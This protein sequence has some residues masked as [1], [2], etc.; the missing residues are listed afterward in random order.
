MKLSY[1]WL[2]TGKPITGATRSSYHL[3]NADRGHRIRVKV[4][5]RKAGYTTVTKVS[6]ATAKV[7]RR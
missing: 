6:A 2:R 7:K 4:T 1:Q 5:G 3:K